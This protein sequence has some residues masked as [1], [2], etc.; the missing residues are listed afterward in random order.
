MAEPVKNKFG[1]K[2][3]GYYGCIPY[4]AE[5]LIQAKRI[6]IEL[7]DGTTLVYDTT[8]KIPKLISYSTTKSYIF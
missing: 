8:G 6:K 3:G 2:A 7:E 1:S 4:L 5:E